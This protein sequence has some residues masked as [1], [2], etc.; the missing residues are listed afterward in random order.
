MI[1]DPKFQNEDE[2]RLWEK[3]YVFAGRPYG[4][5]L[6]DAALEYV[7]TKAP[8]YQ[9]DPLRLGNGSVAAEGYRQWRE[10]RRP[11]GRFKAW[12]RALWRR[13]VQWDPVSTVKPFDTTEAPQVATMWRCHGEDSRGDVIGGVPVSNGE[14]RLEWEQP[15]ETFP[16]PMTLFEGMRLTGEPL[17]ARGDAVLPEVGEA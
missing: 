5:I 8:A 2:K 12:V 4:E 6:A 14:P 13:P 10:S 3:F 9:P 7:R 17:K 15:A 11:L 16:D 1:L